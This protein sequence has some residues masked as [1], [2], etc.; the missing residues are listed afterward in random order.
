MATAWGPGELSEIGRRLVRELGDRR[1][2]DDISAVFTSDL[3]RAVHT[4]EIAFGGSGIP[5]RQDARLR[6][7]D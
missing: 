5:I 2:A 3:R 4:A 6:E 7:C 1:R